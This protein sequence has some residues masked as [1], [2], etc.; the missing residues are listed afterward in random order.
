M[1]EFHRGRIESLLFFND[2]K[3]NYKFQDLQDWICSSDALAVGSADGRVSLW[4][5]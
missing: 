2:P 5:I 1:I 3:F 4:E